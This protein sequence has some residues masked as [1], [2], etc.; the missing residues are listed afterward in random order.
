MKNCI[1][2]QTEHAQ[3]LDIS[4]P[5][6]LLVPVFPEVFS[7]QMLTLSTL[8]SCPTKGIYVSCFECVHVHTLI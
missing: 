2:M 4:L 8:M 1:N 7:Q 5:P 3:N 6:P